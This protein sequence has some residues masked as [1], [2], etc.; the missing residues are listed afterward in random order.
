MAASATALP[1]STAVAPYDALLVLSFGGPEGPSDVMP[2]LERVTGGRGVPPERLAAVAE[3]YQL[4][5]GVS[6][7]NA[8]NRSLVA[9]VSEELTSHGPALPVY[10]GNRNW[11]PLLA[12][13]LQQMADDGV[14][15]AACFVTSAYG[16]YSSCRQYLDDIAA[17]RTAVGAGA[18]VVD[19]LR[20]FFDHPGFISPFVDATAAALQSLGPAAAG[21]HLVFCA[22]SIPV[23]Q[24]DV[25]PYAAQVASACGLV[26]SQL[27]TAL[28]WTLA[29]QSRSGPPTQPWLQPDLDAH[30]A[31][32]ASSSS[33]PTGVVLVPI[34]FVADHMEVVYDLDVVAASQA[35][36]LGLPLARAATPGVAP[37]F[38]AMIR[39]LIVE[40]LSVGAGLDCGEGCCAYQP[41]RRP[42][43]QS[44]G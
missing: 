22:H 20:P 26:A 9:A 40:R 33:P 27:G 14:G 43:A 31:S 32:L 29:W 5:G 10:W 21:A 17:A 34:G 16:G 11:H 7:I 18:P 37:A 8:A 12:D 38:V 2:F 3:H 44:P 30:L 1:A 6:P 41:A 24:S 25:T 36:S 28:P 15:R 13:T 42:D 23:A 4:F 35:A 19:K 39:S